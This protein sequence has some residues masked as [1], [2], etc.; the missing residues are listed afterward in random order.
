MLLV[1]F[2]VAAALACGCGA[3]ASANASLTLERVII[4]SRHGIRTPYGAD[5]IVRLFSL[6]QSAALTLGVAGGAWVGG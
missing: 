3:A 5:Y 6:R 2:V 4:F 1:R